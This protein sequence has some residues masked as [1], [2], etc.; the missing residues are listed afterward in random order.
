[1]EINTVRL[2]KL[3]QRGGKDVSGK[4]H[5]TQICPIRSEGLKVSDNYTQSTST[6]CHISIMKID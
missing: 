3:I 6:G 5:G 4:K 1:M 2:S